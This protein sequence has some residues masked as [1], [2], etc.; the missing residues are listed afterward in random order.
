MFCVPVLFIQNRSNSQV[1]NGRVVFQWEELKA[2][3]RGH[4]QVLWKTSRVWSGHAPPFDLAGGA[5][6]EC[7]GGGGGAAAD[8]IR[9]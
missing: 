3:Q 7:V 5:S 9:R 1:E 2:E 4:R 8:C 6:Q